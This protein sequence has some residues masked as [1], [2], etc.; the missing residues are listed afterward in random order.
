MD[1]FKKINLN[2]NAYEHL[3][4]QL[5]NQVKEMILTG[6]L[7]GHSKLPPIRKFSELLK[8]NKSI[9]I[10]AYKL[11]E[12]ED[13]IYK[14]AGSGTYVKQINLKTEQNSKKYIQYSSH[15]INLASG[16]P[17]EELF[18]VS[19]F[20]KS[21]NDVLDQYK[22]HAFG[23]GDSK[24]N[25]S[26]RKVI[27][28]ELIPEG[29]SITDEQLQI[30]S[31]AQQGID[32]VSKALLK[33]NDFIMIEMPTYTGAL[34]IFKSRGCQFLGV[35]INDGIDFSKFEEQVKKYQPKLFFTMPNLH[36]PTGYTY[37][38][39]EKKKLVALANKYNFFI[40]EDDYSSELI[41]SSE[42]NDKKT[43]MA[44]DENGKV[45]YIKSLSKIFLPGLR[46]G[47]LIAPE[48]IERLITNAKHTT[49]ISTSGLI[50]KTFEYFVKE[51]MWLKQNDLIKKIVLEKYNKAN[52]I[53]EKHLPLGV[54]YI[55]PLGG[56]N[57]WLQ[58]KD[59]IDIS[60]L[61]TYLEDKGIVVAPGNLF[62]LNKVKTKH[63]R[64][65]I[66]S[67]ELD[68]LEDNL[69]LFCAALDDFFNE[70]TPSKNIPIL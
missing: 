57:F 5:F 51:G 53:L 21:I 10:K 67:I 23:Y 6:E 27:I 39:E 35:D 64:I 20:K 19:D 46:L 48:P 30:V 2:N 12:T 60:F 52:E 16:T 25:L 42:K 55:K 66:A 32:I 29:V 9:I 31:G 54:T 44:L 38:L 58:F 45:I 62:Y 65:S 50:Q 11:L 47:Y 26:L 61:V 24:G 18:P 7:T 28:E 49:D 37:T 33:P 68:D 15:M 3:Y 17:S 56:V 36:N 63:I 70:V 1:K 59:G 4:E 34:A 14:K 40:V 41:F 69:K 43:L 8:V 22:G 13:L